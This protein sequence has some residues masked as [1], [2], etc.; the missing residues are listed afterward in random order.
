MTLRFALGLLVLVAPRL[1]AQ[2]PPRQAFT[3]D[4]A[5]DVVSAQVSDLS[6][7][8]R[9][10]LVSVASRRDG[11]GVDYRRDTDPTYLRVSPARLRVIDTRDGTARDVF[12]SA[13]TVRAAAWSP[14]ASRLGALV[15]RDDR[16]EAVIW[17][18]TSGRT[19][20]LPVPRGFYIAESSDLKWSG[21][22]K[23]VVLAL[24]TDAWRQAATA[25]F[26]RMTKGPVF[27]QDGSDPFLAWEKLRREGNVRAVYAID[28]TSGAAI[29]LLPVGRYPQYQLTEDDSLITWSDDVTKKTDYD[30]IFG[31][32]TKVMARRLNGGTAMVVLPST[33]G[34][35]PVW[36]RDGR[37]VAYARDGRV[38]VRA[39]TD[40]APRQV[41]GPDSAAAIRFAADTTASGRAARAKARF[42][43]LRWSPTGD[44]LL[45]SNSEGLWVAPVDRSAMTMVVA[46]NDTVLTTPKVSPVAWSDDGRFIY[47]SSA[48]RTAWERGVVRFD[49]TSSTLQSLVRD[50]RLYG[51]VRLSKS[52]DVLVFSAADGNRPADLHV[53]DAAMQNPRRLTTLNPGLGSRTLA[54]TRLITYRDADGAT[55]Y[56]V[57]YLPASFVATTRYPTLFSVYEDFFDDTFDASL[58]VLASQGY[59]VV[60]PSVGFETGYPGEAW[61]KGVTAAANALI[62]AGIADSSKLGV[63]GTSYGGYAT[64]LLITQTKG[65]R[66]AV[67]ASGK[68][69]M[70][71]FYTDSPRLGVRNIHAAEKSQDRIGATLWEAPQKYIAQSA[72]FFADRITTP[73]LLV[74]GAQ[75]PNVPA[76][77]TREMYFALRRLGKPVTWVNYMNSGHG[78][79]G[80]TAEDFIDYHRR[81]GAFFDRHLKSGA[82]STVVEATSLMGEPLLRPEP[83]GEAR[84]RM[85]QQLAAA[86][87]AFERA[88]TDADSIIWLGR[89]TAYLGRF[90]D[91]IDV[92]TK[93]IAL[94][95]SDARMYRH[96]GHRYLSTRQLPLAIADFERAHALTKGKPDAVEPDGQPNARNI[97]TSTLQGN[98]RYHLG[99]A[100]YLSGQFEKALPLYRQDLA[101]SAGN[102]D[103]LVATS[104]WLYMALRRLGRDTDANAVLAPISASM[105]VIENGAYHRLLLLYKGELKEAD[106]LKD[107]ATAGT[108]EDITLAYGVGNWHLY[109]G[110]Q[111]EAKAIFSRIA[112]AKSQWASFGYL[113]AEA[114]LARI[115]SR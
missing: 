34:I 91:A 36:S 24:R 93:G 73:L 16:I 10:L 6:A 20:T 35:T 18:R 49:R 74:T 92:Y 40:T 32:E 55:R 48:S 100:Y 69:D 59:V 115:S 13:R 54:G 71:S 60:K 28:G 42:N 5:L 41:A 84:E 51:N 9:W 27:V 78:T 19:R 23:R 66:A 17:D 102:N 63:Y 38:F 61:L 80:T 45:V 11:L 64:N 70:V 79:P 29:E 89:R 67:N 65:F 83:Q 31:T 33:K 1:G 44:A 14:D 68:V 72:I 62:E 113:S 21:D 30:V 50:A 57:V 37:R 112:A 77:N 15:L 81:I 106:L 99:L 85:E 76:D 87:A 39:V 22:G 58:N 103:M 26:A 98:I 105:D 97:P 95:P 8:G 3:A 46:T 2:A 53:A 110:R 109:N 47:L 7:D 94:H 12:P 90:N 75:D 56:G 52:G 104:H 107:F 114:E 4:D 88:P 96:R 82:N 108:L 43:V 86:R 111:A 25:E 101:E